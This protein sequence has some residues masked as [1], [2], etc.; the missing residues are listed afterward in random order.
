MFLTSPESCIDSDICFFRQSLTVYIIL[1]TNVFIT[2][3]SYL[4]TQ[5]IRKQKFSDA[6]INYG[7]FGIELSE[8]MLE[9][10]EVSHTLSKCY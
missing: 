1:L 3:S 10:G 9:I 4:N 2:L 8:Q 5:F 7:G 6:D